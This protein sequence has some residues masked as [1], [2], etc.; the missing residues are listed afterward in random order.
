MKPIREKELVFFNKIIED[1]FK[2]KRQTLETEITSEAQKLADKKAPT[3]A[4]QCG[5]EE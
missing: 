5:V 3:M 4:K 2:D 1:K